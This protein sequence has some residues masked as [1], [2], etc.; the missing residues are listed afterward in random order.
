MELDGVQNKMM[1]KILGVGRAVDIDR[2]K[3]ALRAEMD[4]ETDQ[5]Q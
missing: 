5:T 4:E 3:K 1:K 2:L